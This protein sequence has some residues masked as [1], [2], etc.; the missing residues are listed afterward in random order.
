MSIREF[1]KSRNWKVIGKLSRHV[2]H[3]EG[4]TWQYWE[5]EGGNQYTKDKNGWFILTENGDFID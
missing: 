5:D 1:A 2:G 3:L 4:E